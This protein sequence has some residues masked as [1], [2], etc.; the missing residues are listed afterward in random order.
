MSLVKK[1]QINL[2]DERT[3]GNDSGMNARNN[4]WSKYGAKK[5]GGYD[6][7]KERNRAQELELLERAG[8]IS[9]LQKQV[10][11]VVIETQREPDTVGPRGGVKQG[12][13]LEKEAYY[14]AD[15]VYYRDGKMIVEDCKGFRTKEYILKRKLMLKNYG[16]RIYE[17]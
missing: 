7:K 12:K 16:I 4:D 1:A 9:G 13:L 8:E 5:S 10:K 17:T 6:S 14:V 2:L 15:F 3:G 11:F